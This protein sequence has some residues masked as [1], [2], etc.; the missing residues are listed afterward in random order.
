MSLLE[1]LTAIFADAFEQAGLERSYG[2][3]VVSQ[4]PD[5]GQFQCNGALPAAGRAKQKP[6]EVAQRVVDALAQPERFREVSLAGPGFIN[7]SL[8]DDYLTEYIRRVA[9]DSERLGVAPV[10]EPQ[11]TIVDYGG[12]NVAKEMH[13]GHLRAS[14]IGESIKRLLRFMGHPVLGDI[15]LGDWGTQMGQVIMEI[16]RQQPD[17]PYF[18]EAHSGPYPE[19]SP[20]TMEE[21]AE[22]YPVASARYKEDEEF[23]AAAR[24]A[25]V[26]LQEGKPGYRALWQ[27]LVTISKEALERDFAALGVHFELWHG[28][29]T[30][31]HRIAPLLARLQAEGFIEESNGA[32]VVPVA[33]EGDSKE[34][35]PL[36][37]VKSDG[38]VLYGTTD[39]A[40]IEER[41]QEFN[42]KQI[43][44]VV[45]ARQG[46]HFEQVFRAAHKTG[47]AG[48]E[49]RI[50]HLGFGTMN[51]SDGKPFKTRAGGIMKLRDLITMVTDAA[52]RRLDEVGAAQDVDATERAE[53]ARQVGIAALKY[54][55]LS[56][57]RTSDYIFDLERFT[58]FEGRTGPYLLY[59]AVRIKSILRKADERGF[60]AGALLPPAHPEERDLVVRLTHLPDVLARTCDAGAPSFLCDYAYQLAL[61]FNR[62]Y[63]ACHI[64]SEPNAAQQGSWLALCHLCLRYF[65]LI[66][67]LLG[68]EIPERM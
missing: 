35:P 68:L 43:L 52:L 10:R 20:I 60:V 57:H 59:S 65:A 8:A 49:V 28:E 61:A 12:P 31:H 37:L 51:G 18:D 5:L 63:N 23:K 42:A 66:A 4:R 34:V 54:A 6:R 14:I 44:Y 1:E 11:Q 25:T 53:I 58:E 17:L 27:H 45:D 56:N 15:H 29:S 19:T 21:L 26:H 41:V 36:I 48:E 22:L 62:F 39:L 16:Q 32:L 9:A 47:V 7:I 64:L 55:D 2:E 40:T 30:V 24:L 38:A 50:E 46:L 67:E 33:Q 3:V 13:V